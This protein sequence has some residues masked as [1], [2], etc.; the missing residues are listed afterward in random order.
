MINNW[1]RDQQ[2]QG[3]TDEFSSI[4][5]TVSSVVTLGDHRLRQAE[6]TLWLIVLTSRSPA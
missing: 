4:A 3:Q 2:R 6:R 5:T 1:R